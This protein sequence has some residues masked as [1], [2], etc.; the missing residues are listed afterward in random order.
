VYDL[1]LIAKEE[2][3]LQ[4]ITIHRLT[5]IGRRCRM[6]MNVDKLKQLESQ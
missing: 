5:E 4:G 6:E 2:T 3:V 1:V